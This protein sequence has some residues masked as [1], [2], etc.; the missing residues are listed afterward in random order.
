MKTRVYNKADKPPFSY[1]VLTALVIRTFPDKRARLRQIYAKLEDFFP[2]LASSKS[3]WK[4]SVRHNLVQHE[5]FVKHKS[6]GSHSLWT[7][8]LAKIPEA[9][10]KRQVRGTAS[11]SSTEFIRDIREIFNFELGRFTKNM[12]Q[13]SRSSSEPCLNYKSSENASTGSSEYHGSTP[14]SAASLMSSSDKST[15]DKLAVVTHAFVTLQRS[16]ATFSELWE[17]IILRRMTET[18]TE[19]EVYELLTT[20]AVFIKH[21]SENGEFFQISF[22]NL[23]RYHR[24][25]MLAHYFCSR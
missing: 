13:P 15:N 1:G 18:I 8:E 2:S 11:L 10:F 17:Q 3:A 14:L 4:D 19:Y 12:D 25:S 7:V 24:Y 22:S 21:V 16:A 23:D 6:S 5:Y 9:Q 20:N